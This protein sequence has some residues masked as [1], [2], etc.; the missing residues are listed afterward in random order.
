[1]IEGNWFA[2]VRGGSLKVRSA[3]V[4][5]AEVRPAEVHAHWLVLAPPRVPGVDSL[6]EPSELLVIGHAASPCWKH[7][8]RRAGA[9][10][11]SA[12]V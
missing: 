12:H 3:E 2:P 6:H 11:Q 8:C 10:G 9:A 7:Q 1:M 5:H 4:R